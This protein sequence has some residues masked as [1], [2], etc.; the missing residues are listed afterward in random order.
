MSGID[1]IFAVKGGKLNYT[2]RTLRE[3]ADPLT[4]IEGGR[5]AWWYCREK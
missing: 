4:F 5:D 1:G 2:G 3:K